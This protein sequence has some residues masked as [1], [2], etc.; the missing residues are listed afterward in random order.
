MFRPLLAIFMRNTQLFQ[1][2]ALPTTDPLF[3]A[4]GPIFIRLFLWCF[5]VL[6]QRKMLWPGSLIYL[7]E[8][9]Y[10]SQVLSNSPVIST[11]AY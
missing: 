5:K 10:A 4:V 6:L 1:E 11:P 8:L 7:S 9:R 3:Y 2:A